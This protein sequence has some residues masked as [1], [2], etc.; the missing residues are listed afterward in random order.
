MKI[1]T[2]NVN[3]FRGADKGPN[4]Y[5]NEKVLTSNLFAL[6]A[7]VDSL[8]CDADDLIILQEVPHKIW[9]KSIRPG[10]W[11][12]NPFHQKF[13]DMF[14]EQYKVIVPNHLI[15]SVQCTVA[16]CTINSRWNRIEIEHEKLVYDERYSYGNKLLELR[17]NDEITLL[18]LH[19]TEDE[20]WKMV[21]DACNMRKHTI[22]VGDFN[23][24]ESRGSMKNKPQELRKAGYYSCIP[25]NVITDY[26]YNSSIDNIYIDSNFEIKNTMSISVK[27]LDAFKTDHALCGL[28]IHEDTFPQAGIVFGDDDAT[29]EEA[30]DFLDGKLSD[31][32]ELEYF[33]DE[34]LCNV[35]EDDQEEVFDKDD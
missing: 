30:E 33:Y 18:G 6:K 10:R 21:L 14:E 11:K 7:V 19:I 27:K 13:H 2:L 32:E 34:M 17:Y 35:D 8:S 9:D 3:G 12:N 28:E 29:E 1:Y 5:V 22:I 31:S 23:A 26:K 25:N 20:I 16:L 15:S 24:Y 4:E